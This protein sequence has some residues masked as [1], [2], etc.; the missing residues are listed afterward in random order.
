MSNPS[1]PVDPAK[2]ISRRK[3]IGAMAAGASLTGFPMINF[4]RYAL[5]AQPFYEY[6]ARAID[7]I[8][9]S[10]VFDLKHALHLNPD[11][12]RRWF[13]HPESFGEEAWQRFRSTGLTG[14]QTTVEWHEDVLLDYAMHN[15]FIATNHQYFTRIDSVQSIESIM[16]S[17]KIGIMLG[18]ENSDH[19]HTLEDVDQFYALGQRISQLTYNSQN[20]LGSGATDRV[21]GGLSDYGAAVIERMNAIGMLVDVSHCGEATTLDGIDS[22]TN[23]VIISHATCRALVPKQPRTKT[24]EAIKLM[25]KKGGIMGIAFLRVFVRD[26]EPTTVE[27]ALDHIDH[28]VK[29]VGIEHVAVGSD[30]D[31][32]GYDDLPRAMVEKSKANLKPG[33]YQFRDKDDVDGLNH[34]RRMFDLAEGLIRRDYSDDNIRLILGGNVKRVL[35]QVWTP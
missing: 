1:T 16:G 20:R 27:H 14:M 31:L 6:S 5:F 2:K 13:Y 34:P 8:G 4:D 28:V 30:I 24:D 21:D 35:T 15:S 3:L 19:F 17:G 11:I 33:T 22:S 7:L 32:D 23:P 12:L 10:F 25:A 18:S 9:D 29:L 26:R